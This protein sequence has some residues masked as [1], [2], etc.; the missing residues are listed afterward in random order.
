MVKRVLNLKSYENM[1]WALVQPGML[2]LV[3]FYFFRDL[4]DCE[5]TTLKFRAEAL[6]NQ[7]WTDD[8]IFFFF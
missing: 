6:E 3:T 2:G 1:P 5:G 4:Q 8:K 7:L